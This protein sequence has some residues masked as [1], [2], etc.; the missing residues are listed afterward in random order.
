MGEWHTH[1]E[2]VPSPSPTDINSWRTNL[3][4]NEELVLIIVGRTNFWIGKQL[5]KEISTLQQV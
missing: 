3:V 4:S 1:P 2:D 5:F